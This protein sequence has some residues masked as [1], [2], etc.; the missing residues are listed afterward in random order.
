M[1]DKLKKE[2]LSDIYT[3]QNDIDCLKSS[4]LNA[5]EYYEFKNCVQASMTKFEYIP[6]IPG[7][8]KSVG[9]LL[10]SLSI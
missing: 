2:I 5:L 4:K 6:S 7:T 3:I 9:K 10:S 1:I 8:I